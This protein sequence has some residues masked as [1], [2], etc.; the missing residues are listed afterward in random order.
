MADIAQP[1]PPPTRRED[2]VELV[3]GLDVVDPFRWLESGESPE[4]ADWVARQNAHTR[5][6]LDARPD[7]ERWLER[8]SALVALPTV[9]EC[10]VRG[11]HLIVL[12]RAAG[13][14]QHA[15]YLRSATDPTAPGRLLLDPAAGV[16]DA[17]MAIDWFEADD[18]GTTTAGSSSSD[19]GGPP[20]LK[21]DADSVAA[22]DKASAPS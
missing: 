5:Q 18:T 19:D 2:V 21:L 13:A 20:A 4:V 11:E 6:A 3:H 12:E 14:D 15:L 10:Q 1:G 17:A 22:I 16:A 9:L 8:L 7:R